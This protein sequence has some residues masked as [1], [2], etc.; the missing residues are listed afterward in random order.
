MAPTQ[1][2][3]MAEQFLSDEQWAVALQLFA[4]LVDSAEPALLIASQSDE[5]IR[6]ALQNLWRQHLYAEKLRFLED[7]ITIVS[8]LTCAGPSVFHP[9]QILVDR[10]AVLRLLGRGGMGEVYL[11]DDQRLRETVALKTIK[12]EFAKESYNRD[13]FLAEV[14]NS[15]R[16]THPNVCRIFD[17]FEHDGVPFYS[18]EYVAGPTLAEVLVAGSLDRERAKSL[19]IQIAEGLWAA[20]KN[21]ILHCDFKPANILLAGSGKN[22]RAVITDFGLA[23]A[24]GLADPVSHTQIVA[25]TPSYMAPELLKGQ[26]ATVRSDIYAFGKVLRA[27]LPENKLGPEC[28]AVDPR[29][30]PES[31][32][33]VLKHLHAHST[34][35][36]WI[37]GLLLG[38][39]GSA[40]YL[41]E[42]SR[43][44]I[45]L[46]SRQRVLVN[47]FRPESGDTPRIVRNLLI[48]ALRQSPFLSVV[49]DRAYLASN[50]PTLLNAGYAFPLGDLLAN[51]RNNKVNL[52]IDGSLENMGQG[53]RLVVN[54]YD[55]V[56]F[57]P[58]YT[59]RIEVSN[60]GELVHLAELAATNL[61]VS[62][63]GESSMHSTYMPLEQITSSSAEAVDYYFRA[64]F[65]YEKSDATSALVLLD[66]A[67]KSDPGFVLAH[68]YRA[69]ALGSQG[70]TEKAESSEEKAFANRLRVTERE[71]NWID[72]L[73]YNL[74]GAWVE[75]AAALQKN[76]TLF[77]D[78]AVFERQLAFALTRLG[79]YAE[80]IPHNRRAV[81]LDPFSE[82][83]RSELLVNLAEANQVNECLAEAQKL[84]ASGRSPNMIHR[85]LALAYMQEGNYDRSL[86]ECRELGNG[87]SERESWSRLLSLCPLIMKGR[88]IEAIQSVEGDLASDSARLSLDK[89][90]TFA[91]M[92]RNALGQLQRL[93]DQPALAAEQ[94][95]FLVH[96]RPLGANLVQLREGCALAF[97][98][99]EMALAEHGLS[100]LQELAAR[101]PSGHSQSAVWLT[102]AM[103]KDVQ[104]DNGATELFAKAKGAW[105]DPLNLFYI[106]RWEGKTNLMEAQLTSLTELERLRGKVYKHHFAGLVV[107]GW[108]EQARCLQSLSRFAESLRMYQRVVE[109]W[110]G[111]QAA[112]SLMRQTRKELDDLKGKLQ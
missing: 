84:D 21:S 57:T 92:R 55:P 14:Q 96:L 46:G 47:G 19:A 91:Y 4:Q 22:E 86:S 72:S 49:G 35:R 23:R 102:R 82:N 13:R 20:H 67:L 56:D 11:A 12:R 81:E 18:M 24:L 63:F 31:L 3:N 95:E 69:L 83:N 28:E 25:G 42:H 27:M 1:K 75:S 59:T 15:R 71:R 29:D 51:S 37:A 105:P 38:A 112:G 93:I 111:S 103:L 101:Y 36:N 98:L 8:D 78:E 7:Q 17:L 104:G 50:G 44:R 53:L 89:E 2:T 66:Q 74:T 94:A 6:S 106:A 60:R 45:P 61:R 100:R 33:H 109:H 80:A 34:R 43:P 65:A 108:L 32:E 41:Y 87:A 64:V 10:F 26:C 99:N 58:R 77:P 5:G 110:G 62:A 79:R 16:V 107:L 40:L 39:G 85:A 9:G 76:T 30:R 88:F 52:A 70:L 73:Y 48:M 54:V 90:E 68:H 97:D